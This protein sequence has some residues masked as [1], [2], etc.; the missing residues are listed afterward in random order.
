MEA[1]IPK[2]NTSSNEIVKLND[3]SGNNKTRN[4]KL[5]EKQDNA[6]RT[7]SYEKASKKPLAYNKNLG[8]HSAIECKKQAKKSKHKLDT[9]TKRENKGTD[10]NIVMNRSIIENTEG[11]KIQPGHTFRSHVTGNIIAFKTIL[12]KY[13]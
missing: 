8:P 4:N 7:F 11:S 6:I 2:K 13:V 3:A 10:R 9:K 12:V 1:P 5:L